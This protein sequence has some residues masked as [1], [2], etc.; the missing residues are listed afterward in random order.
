MPPLDG[1]RVRNVVPVA[2][3]Q[4]QQIDFLPCKTRI[5]SLR[6]VEK[7]VATRRLNQKAIRLV[8]PAGKSF[9]LQ[10]ICPV[11]AKWLIFLAQSASQGDLLLSSL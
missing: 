3:R 10:H 9:E 8:G 1:R 6:R 11:E 7:N 4:N 2:V 5:R